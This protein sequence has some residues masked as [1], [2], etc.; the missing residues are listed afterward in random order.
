M[1]KIF[2]FALLS[3]LLA[4]CGA[5]DDDTK[6]EAWLDVNVNNVAGTWQLAEWNGA[7]L[8]VGSYVYLKLIRR[9]CLFEMTQNV[10]SF[11]KR[12]LTGRF[13]IANDEERGAMIRGLYDHGAGDWKHA[14]L[15]SELSA[16]R[17]VWTALD[18]P[19]D[20]SVYVRIESIPEDLE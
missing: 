8:P 12:E 20:I 17:M 10:D 7:P 16:D 15:I 6:A 4:L 11:Q 2:K 1:K 9:D 14:Y 13:G 18:D 3:L 5:C 19:D